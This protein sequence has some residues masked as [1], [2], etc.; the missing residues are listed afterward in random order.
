[1]ARARFRFY[2][3]LNDFLPPA[4][5]GHEFECE[6]ARRAT[7]KHM[8]EALGVPH[9]EVELVLVNGQPAGFGRVLADA[10]RVAV[11]PGFEAL[12]VS[13]LAPLR[14][15]LP[16]RPS[17]VADVHLGG[18]ARQLRMA[19]FDTIWENNLDDAEIAQISIDQGRIVLTRDRE[20]LKRRGIIHGCYVRAL[21][22]A[23][24]AQEIFARLDLGAS[25]RP[26]TLCL[27]CNEPLREVT[28]QEVLARLPPRTSL[29]YQRFC[30]CDRCQRVFWQG[31]HWRRMLDLLGVWSAAD[32]AGEESAAPGR[33]GGD[34]G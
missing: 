32:V 9:T 21:R 23:E 10:D 22:P 34:C 19:G 14:E 20:L 15:P 8:I 24:Q 25:A 5:R 33:S 29:H 13:A 28:K 31:P 17:F 27:H 16:G 7:V 18:L 6:C 3:R 11:Y 30:T 12:D 26:F 4:R 1:M 2:Q